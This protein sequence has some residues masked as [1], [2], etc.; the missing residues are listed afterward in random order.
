[1][2]TL[3]SAI[4][5]KI[6]LYFEIPRARL[7][8][9]VIPIS[10]PSWTWQVGDSNWLCL[11]S[12]GCEWIESDQNCTRVIFSKDSIWC[13]IVKKR[14]AFMLWSAH[15]DTK[16]Y[17]WHSSATEKGSGLPRAYFDHPTWLAGPPVQ[18][19]EMGDVQQQWWLFSDGYKNSHHSTLLPTLVLFPLKEAEQ[20]KWH[21]G[22]WMYYSHFCS[23][24]FGFGQI[25]EK[26]HV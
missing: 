7:G 23:C 21:T 15:V 6:H 20:Q 3:I 22:R 10:P 25:T 18:L 2:K 5:F 24:V 13:C 19:E 26:R 4:I 8:H 14:V 1:M 12:I 16:V 9:L 11:I 17:L